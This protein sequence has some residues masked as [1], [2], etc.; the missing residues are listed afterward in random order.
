ML[1]SLSIVLVIGSIIKENGR[2][3]TIK[4]VGG[5]LI[6]SGLLVLGGESDIGIFKESIEGDGMIKTCKVLLVIV[7][8]LCMLEGVVKGLERKWEY[9]MLYLLNMLGIIILVTS[10]NLITLYI[11]L[12]IQSLVNYV[13]VGYSRKSSYSTEASLKYFIIGSVG[14]GVILL[15]LSLMYQGTGSIVMEEISRVL[16]LGVEDKKIEISIVMLLIGIGL[17]LSAGPLHQWYIDV[18]DGSEIRSARIIS[19]LPKIG[20]ICALIKILLMIGQM[21]NSIVLNV[22]SIGSMVISVIGGYYQRKIRRFIGYSSVGHLG[23]MYIVLNNL[24][25]LNG[26]ESL[27]MY[28]GIYTLMTL[29]VWGLVESYKIVYIEEL[30]SISKKNKYVGGTVLLL[31]LSMAGIPPLAGFFIKLDLLIDGLKA[32]NTILVSVAILCTVLGGFNYLRW[33]K[34]V[35]YDRNEMMLLKKTRLTTETSILLSWIIGLLLL[36]IVV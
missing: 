34:V 5:I 33:L 27:L 19:I 29:G 11:G 9:G 15:G 16:L 17:K 2:E 35:Y 12:E 22:L 4:L 21:S 26:G 32:G 1:M 24:T 20:G 14:S 6:L 10:K 31:C 18:V 28:L 30:G 25:E 13:L 23:Y 7:G 3:R 8:G 36:F